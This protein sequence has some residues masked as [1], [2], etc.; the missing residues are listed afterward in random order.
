M[1]APQQAKTTRRAALQQQRAELART[2]SQQRQRLEEFLTAQRGRLGEAENQLS[3]QLR[4]QDGRRLQ[5]RDEL[6]RR[7]KRLAARRKALAA[8]EAALA[9]REAAMAQEAQ[10]LEARTERLRTQ[11]E[12][13]E[14]TESRLA[15]RDAALRQEVQQVQADQDELRQRREQLQAAES[16]LQRRQQQTSTS[17]GEAGEAGQSSQANEATRDL[18][19]RLKMA[20][21]DLREL[22]A[23]N[24]ELLKK[25]GSGS[26]TGRGGDKQ[27][28]KWEEQKRMI[29]AALESQC[30]AED[31]P[32]RSQ[33][34]RIE[35]IVRTTDEAL[36][37]KD[38]EIE[39]L[40]LILQDQSGKIEGAVLGAAALGEILDGDAVIREE[41]ENL[42]RLQEHWK[43]MSRQAE[44][45]I[46]LERAKLARQRAELEEQSSIFKTEMAR[47]QPR[48]GE[49]AKPD[50]PSRGWRARLGLKGPPK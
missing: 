35:E 13:L 45:D 38:R 6:C 3:Q 41:R 27:P 43:E 4:R 44:I 20:L 47:S 17:S 1:E 29:L 48:A 50:H 42:Q 7:Q 32:Q 30:D 46:S 33:R 9:A 36:A 2:L 16:D 5:A 26:S 12:A 49:E 28:L 24:A 31:D 37:V 14:Q 23:E 11:Q 8:H 19:E 39:E 40:K 34:Q 22:K 15:Q 10:R 25:A 21:A 18:Q